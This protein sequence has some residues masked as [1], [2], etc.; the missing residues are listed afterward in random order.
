MIRHF[1]CLANSYKYGGRCLAGI[2][3]DL[4]ADGKQYIIQRRE[5]NNPCWIRPVQEGT[6]HESIANEIAQNIRLLDILEIEVTETCGRGCQ[7]ENVYFKDLK[8]ANHLKC[9]DDH[10]LE[11]CSNERCVLYSPRTYLTESEYLRGNHS[12]MLIQPEK[13]SIVVES[14]ETEDG[15]Q[16]RKYYAQFIYRGDEYKL[17]ITDPEYLN[18]MDSFSSVALTGDF[19]TGTFYFAISMAAEPWNGLHYKLLAGIVDMRLSQKTKQ[20]DDAAYQSE[21]YRLAEE[22]SEKTNKCLFITGKAGTGKTTFLRRLRE[23][24]PKNIAVVAP[25]G[26]AAINAGG[27]TIHSFFQL[28]MRMI[29]PTQQSYRQMFAEQRMMQRKRQ[30][31]YHLEMLVIDEISMVRADVLD[32]IDAVLRHYRYRRDLPFGGVQVVMIGDLMQLQPV[33]HGDEEREAMAKYY[34]G[35]YFFQSKV[36]QEVRPVYIELDHVFRQQNEDFVRLLNEVRE[37]KL[38]DVSRAMLAAR[39]IPDYNQRSKVRSQT[40]ADDDFHITL[41]THN[42]QAD[43]L[44]HRRLDEL[45]GRTY[46][47]KAEVLRDFPENSYP[48]EETLT[49]KEGARVMFIRNDDRKPRRFY[50]GKLGIVKAIDEREE[51]ILV[52]CE[53][54]DIEVEPVTWENI[55]YKED[56]QTGKIEEELLGTFTQF[57]LR[58]AWAI[59]I[60]KSQGLTFDRVIIDAERAFA[61]GQ[62]YVALSRCR[63]LE[64]II[65]SSP[66]QHVS[67]GN[68]RQVLNYVNTQPTTEQSAAILGPAQKDYQLQLFTELYDVKRLLTMI[69][70]LQKHVTKC[71]SFNA[72]TLP[73]L[74]DLKLQVLGLVEVSEKFQQQLARI[75]SD[76]SHDYIQQR[77][78]AAAGYFVPKVQ[79]LADQVGEHPCRCKNKA[80]TSDFD[81]I[82]SDL[83]LLLSQKTALMKAVSIEASTESYLHAKSKFVAAPMQTR[84]AFGK[85][86][87]TKEKKASVKVQGFL[88]ADT[89]GD[90]QAQQVSDSEE[91]QEDQ[92]LFERLRL[93]R[94]NIAKDENVPAFVVFPDRTLH[95]LAIH[96]P[97]SVSA[98]TQIYGVGKNKIEKYGE[99]FVESINEYIGKSDS[100]QQNIVLDPAQ[101]YTQK[102]KEKYENAYAKWT[103]EEEQKLVEMKKSGVTMKTIIK[104]LK[105]NK[106]AIIRRL[107]KLGL[108]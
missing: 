98:M 84:S 34:D 17:P 68:D 13:P 76:S 103:H 67:L 78:T 100:L 83:Y 79:A 6:E 10:L 106:R 46:H 42:Q 47:F 23:M 9:D 1:I 94:L 72:E 44:N 81:T 52:S 99:Q 11:L 40:T 36:M 61:A 3:I 31:L 37:N 70:Q 74:D 16:K 87:K 21:A 29:V 85:P 90:A 89:G 39:Y 5:D 69:E 35:P 8:I 105:R 57:P 91:P 73:F 43:D 14:K 30:M 15:Q 28:P 107:K 101:N 108:S 66:L 7:A 51:T 4:S 96:K 102:Q 12:L 2:E 55:R 97:T 27:M 95:E 104:T 65:L 92:K 38:S 45:N 88:I 86:Q 50:N 60:H 41:T 56:P 71:V 64:G 59:T 26:V 18:R 24:S 20:S 63:T 25:T 93:L 33:V 75:I 82:I 22:F 32:A 58:L 53:D 19:P 77:L 49:L 54:G 62:V 48:T 80:D